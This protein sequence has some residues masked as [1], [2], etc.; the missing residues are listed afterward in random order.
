MFR[1]WRKTQRTIAIGADIEVAEPGF[2]DPLVDHFDL[3]LL[4]DDLPSAQRDV[5]K[6]RFLEDL[7]VSEAGKRLGKSDGAVRQLQFQAIRRLRAG[8][9]VLLLVIGLAAA[10]A[11]TRDGVSQQSIDVIEQPT[12]T[13]SPFEEVSDRSELVVD[14][15]E[16][17]EPADASAR[18]KP[19]EPA[20]AS[21]RLEPFVYE[22]F[23]QDVVDAPSAHP[24]W[25]TSHGAALVEFVSAG[26][27]YS[28][29]SG[30]QLATEGGALQ[31]SSIDGRTAMTRTLNSEQVP[32]Y[33]YW[34][35]FLLRVDSDQWGDAFWTP[36]GV[37]DRGGFGIQQSDYF[38]FVNGGR[39]ETLI[40]SGRT[41]LL[42]GHIED[43][44]AVMWV[45]PQ[46]DE[47]GLPH[48]EY[49]N[50]PDGR[51]PVSPFRGSV[52]LWFNSIGD[53]TYTVDEI[54]IGENFASVTPW[55]S[56]RTG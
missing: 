39:T 25:S 17:S 12:T 55:V 30:R 1:E 4:L 51:F 8:F 15:I 11:L 35:S 38:R 36:D 27:K 31:I 43:E 32:E 21:A 13:V 56:E 24:P 28:D 49:I 40:E 9:V 33:G 41:Y 26:L 37:I 48:Q 16:P 52:E 7:S 47:P 5:M 23:D 45:D 46:L 50:P 54:R 44:G 6:L 19:S 53:G 29:D 34:V 22:S 3:E 14:V 2:E 10:F 20:D 18:P 42:V